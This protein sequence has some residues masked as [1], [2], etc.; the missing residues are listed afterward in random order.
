RQSQACDGC[1]IKKRKCDGVRPVCS[2]C[3]KSR[4][5]DRQEVK[6]TYVS[7]TKKRGP[8]RGQR[9]ELLDRIAGLETML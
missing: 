5:K 2:Q 6:C 4:V 9:A 7:V 8:P 1:R 3:R